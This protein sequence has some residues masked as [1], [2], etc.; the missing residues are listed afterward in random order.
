[1]KK[2]STYLFWI[3]LAIVLGTTV[4]LSLVA[5]FINLAKYIL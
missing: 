3:I 1:M 5:A 2:Y 4:G